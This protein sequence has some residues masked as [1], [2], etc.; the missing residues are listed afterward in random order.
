MFDLVDRVKGTVKQVAGAV[1]GDD[2]LKR[3][4]AL[5]HEKVE[6]SKTAKDAAAKSRQAPRW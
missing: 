6:A 3:E 2:D 1:L 4:G 5:H